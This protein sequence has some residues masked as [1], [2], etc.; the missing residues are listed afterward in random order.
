MSRNLYNFNVDKSYSPN[1]PN[2]P[3]GSDA[4]V[5][6][7]YA[8]D[9]TRWRVAAWHP[10]HTDKMGHLLFHVVVGHLQYAATIQ[11]AREHDEALSVE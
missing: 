5:H 10:C 11:S 6:D 2:C 7:A 9:Y 3:Q 1:D 8:G 4:H